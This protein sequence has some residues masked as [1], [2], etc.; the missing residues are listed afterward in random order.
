[1]RLLALDTATEACTV[2]L[3]T[4]HGL[5][6]ESV[7]IGRGHAQEILGMVDRVLAQGGVTL[8]SLSGIAAGIG[9]GSFTGVRV[10][11]AVAQGLAFGAGLPVVPVTSLEALALAAIGRGAAR[12]LACLDARMGEVYWGCYVAQPAG[13]LSAA[14]APAVGPPAGV[15]LPEADPRLGSGPFV[16]IGR[17]FAVY[18]ERRSRRRSSAAS[19]RRDGSPR[20]RAAR[21]GRR[22][23]PPVSGAFVRARQGRQDGGG[24]RRRP[25]SRRRSACW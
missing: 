13:L 1:M 5:I 11:V 21:G 23:R 22:D 9:P 14:G 8:A 10:S 17:G 6:C 2:A 12:A 25:T 15:R 18:T 7:E 24:T 3:L 16:G 4:E 19:G 20:R